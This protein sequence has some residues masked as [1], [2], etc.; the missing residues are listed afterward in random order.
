M[1]R[2]DEAQE[3]VRGFAERLRAQQPD[4]FGAPVRVTDP[5]VQAEARLATLAEKMESAEVLMV[6]QWIDLA[7]TQRN[8]GNEESATNLGD[9][10]T[11]LDLVEEQ[12]R[13]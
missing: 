9:A 1:N 3:Q 11:Y 2:N 7:R 8:E 10:L 12:H 4:L 6:G 13:S 5:F